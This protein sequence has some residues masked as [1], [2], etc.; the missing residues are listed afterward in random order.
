MTRQVNPVPVAAYLRTSSAV[1]VGTDKD[2]D[3]RQRSAILSFAERVG[4]TVAAEF[5]DAAVSGSDPIESRPG[6]TA[7]LDWVETSKATIV[8][9]EDA[10]CFARSLVA[11]ELGL[12]VLE[13]RGVRVLTSN[14]DDL[15]ASDDPLR[16]AQRQIA[17]AFMQLEKTRLVLKLREAR[18]RKRAATGV[19]CEGRK[20]HVEMNPELV[21]E[22]KK[23]RRRRPKGGQRS[24]RDIAVILAER[25]HLN[26]NGRQ[27]DPSSIRSML[28]R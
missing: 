27:Y 3:K 28:V 13:Q 25:G 11:Q 24:Y 8:I 17:G 19:K 1:N 18:K 22:V 2:S 12:V 6:F 16:V 21:A 7:L 5:Y 20:S 10:S 26:S 15:T 4:Y 23:L 9:V 14:G